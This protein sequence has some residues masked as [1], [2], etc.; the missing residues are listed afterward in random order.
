[1]LFRGLEAAWP[2]WLAGRELRGYVV[3]RPR[4]ASQVLS[5]TLGAGKDDKVLREGWW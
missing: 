5:A 4:D 1:M 3:N 2:V